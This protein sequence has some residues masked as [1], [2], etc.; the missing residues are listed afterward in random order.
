MG[1]RGGIIGAGIG[2]I[3]TAAIAFSASWSSPERRAWVS[4]SPPATPTA[5]T[6]SGN[7]T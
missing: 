1:G 2:T 5:R 4:P 7:P 6:A 3:A